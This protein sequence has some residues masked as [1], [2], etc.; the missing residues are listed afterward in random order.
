[1]II[2]FRPTIRCYYFLSPICCP[3]LS[4]AASCPPPQYQLLFFLSLPTEETPAHLLLS[5]GA[6]NGVLLLLST[7]Y[8]KKVIGA[9]LEQ[10]GTRLG[11]INTREHPSRCLVGLSYGEDTFSGSSSSRAPLSL[12]PWLNSKRLAS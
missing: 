8:R 4:S 3:S 5:G 6:W 12:C 9:H 10:V 2:L 11:L 7:I 1:M